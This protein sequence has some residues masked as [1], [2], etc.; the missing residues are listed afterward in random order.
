MFRSRGIRVDKKN[1]GSHST[2]LYYDD[3][4][5]VHNEVIEKYVEE[6]ILNYFEYATDKSGNIVAYNL[7]NNLFVDNSTLYNDLSRENMQILDNISINIDSRIKNYTTGFRMDGD[8]IKNSVFYFYP[9][10]ETSERYK[11]KG[12]DDKREIID[13]ISKLACY[14]GLSD[15][16]KRELLELSN[17]T[18]K[19]KGISVEFKPTDVEMKLYLRISTDKVYDYLGN[20]I[21]KS[22]FVKFGDVALFSVRIVGKDVEG[23]NLYYLK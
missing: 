21:E 10:I 5:L 17:I 14:F 7:H 19:F 9:T 15:I 22:E 3:E 18:T 12:I 2:K 8:E 11:I 4:R 1:R 23:Y 6:S 16:S 20:L 13:T